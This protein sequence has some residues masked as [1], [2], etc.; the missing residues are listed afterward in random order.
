MNQSTSIVCPANYVPA[1][2]VGFSDTG[3]NLAIVD[4]GQP[5][6]VAISGNQPI[7]VENYTA[8]APSPLEGEST[9]STIVGPFLPV[10]G[11]PVVLTLSGVWEGSVQLARSSDGGTTRHPVTV[12]GL[13]W[14]NYTANACEAVWEEQEAG[15]GLY[16]EITLTSGTV[17]YR[18]AQ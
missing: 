17:T 6:P 16:L 1:F 10:S 9:T 11:R 4:P 15:A 13:A 7:A 14:G 5:L 2:A 3:G 12:A 18:L 8:P